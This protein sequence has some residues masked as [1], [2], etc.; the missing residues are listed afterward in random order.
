[1]QN[2]D[3]QPINHMPVQSSSVRSIG[4]DKESGELHVTFNDGGRY[5]YHGVPENVHQSLMMSGS[6]GNFLHHNVK[7]AFEFTKL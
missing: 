7:N 6:K 3:K 1:M 5:M 2:R 4:Y